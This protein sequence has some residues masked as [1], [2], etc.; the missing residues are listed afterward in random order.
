MG[1]S[2]WRHNV[3]F[4]AAGLLAVLA[5]LGF[6]LLRPPLL[7]SKVLVDVPAS[8]Q[9]QTQAVIAGSEPVLLAASHSDPALSFEQLLR[10][11]KVV[12]SSS[13]LL[14]ITVSAK[15]AAQAQDGANAVARSYVAFVRSP[16]APGVQVLARMVC[17]P[18]SAGVCASPARGTGLSAW[19]AETTGFGT[20]V[21]LV[22]GVIA[23]FA[24]VRPRPTT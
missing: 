19:V 17:S 16:G 1:W 20:L 10:Q 7:S 14:A 11:V 12:V 22:L 23:A 4:G 2:A 6:A 15:T 9:I 5:T 13:N 24:L 21:G 18:G 3:V 8:K